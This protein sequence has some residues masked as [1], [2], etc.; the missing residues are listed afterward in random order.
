MSV[1]VVSCGR[2]GTN[3]AVSLLSGSPDLNMTQEVEN[4]KIFTSPT[5][6]G[7]KYL[8]KTDTTYMGNFKQLKRLMELN[9]NLKLVWTIRDPRDVLMSKIRRGQPKSR[10]GDGPTLSADATPKGAIESLRKMYNTY[11]K[12]VE[13]YPNRTTLVTMEDMILNTENVAKGLCEFLNVEYDDKMIN[14]PNR[15]K[16]QQKVKRYGR[17]I[18]KGQVALWE[19]WGTAYGG[20]FKDNNLDMDKHFESV[21]DIIEYF[22]YG[23]IVD[24]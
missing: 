21:V 14:F 16:N 6:L 23:K 17:K 22:D 4:K 8:A 10:G 3:V 5:K 11:K 19:N 15:I 7:D 12:C 1:V 2:T 9:P 13:I 24:A 18:N 20:Y